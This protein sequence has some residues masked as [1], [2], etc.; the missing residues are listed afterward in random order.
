MLLDFTICLVR[1][2]FISNNRV[3]LL[4]R[5]QFSADTLRRPKQYSA[6]SP[7]S[8][9]LV[10]SFVNASISAFDNSFDVFASTFKLGFFV[11]D[12]VHLNAKTVSWK[13][14][15][16]S[17]RIV[18]MVCYRIECPALQSAHFFLRA[19]FNWAFRNWLLHSAY[20]VVSSNSFS[21]TVQ[22]VEWH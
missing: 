3:R 15:L 16:L 1:D 13:G 12:A 22:V 11:V 19:I 4:S 5:S 9:L 20:V 7:I 10:R 8:R 2:E 18:S 6:D 21:N 14:W 17:G